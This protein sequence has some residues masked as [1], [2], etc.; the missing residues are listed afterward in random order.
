MKKLI[1][2]FLAG[3]LALSMLS[4]AGNSQD[5][6][7]TSAEGADSAVRLTSAVHLRSKASIASE[8]LS[9]IAAGE[10]VTLLS[11]E[12]D[13]A[14]VSYKGTE[15]YVLAEY[16]IKGGKPVKADDAGTEAST[17]APESGETDDPSQESST[18]STG[19][20][21]TTASTDDTDAPTDTTASQTPASTA[22]PSTSASYADPGNGVLYDNGLFDLSGLSNKSIPYGNDWED[23]DSIGLA[24]GVHYYENLYGKYHSVYYL[25]TNGEKIIYLTMDEGYEAGYTP[26]ILDILKEKGVHAVFFVTKQFY[27][28]DPEL[29]RRM[30]NEGHVIGNHTCRHPSGGYP[31]YVDANGLDSFTEDVSTL[32]KLIYDSFGYTMKLFRFPE[33]EASELLMAKL[34][35]LGYTPVFWS[36]A[37]RDFVMDDQPDPAVTLKRCVD[38]LAPGCVY[39]LHAV[40]SSNTA[41]LA[42]FIDQARALGYEFGEFPV[43]QVSAR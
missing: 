43:D 32:H 13:W 16:L 5:K 17:E 27:D 40:S 38:H 1:V 21:G 24:S 39:L 20:E 28:S 9:Q 29:I 2:I 35:N 34:N 36:Y 30:I 31:K 12:G 19:E 25:K 18:G 7:K 22:A 3:L 33:G 14:K 6:T 41:A 42:D 15:G 26:K 23:K 11:L 8:S 10:E 4:C 37:H